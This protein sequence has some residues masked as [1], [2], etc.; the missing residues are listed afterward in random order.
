MAR[1]KYNQYTAT[2]VG[3]GRFP[4]DMLR[5]DS[6]VPKNKDSWNAVMERGGNEPREAVV[7]YYREVGAVRGLTKARWES[8]GWSIVQDDFR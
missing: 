2:V 7:T 5:Y 4:A 8:Y 3:K 1:T 6:C